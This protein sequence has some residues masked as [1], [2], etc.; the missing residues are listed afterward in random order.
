MMVK[1]EGEGEGVG[2]MGLIRSHPPWLS[3]Y[4]IKKKL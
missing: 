2:E 3:T 4:F 1:G